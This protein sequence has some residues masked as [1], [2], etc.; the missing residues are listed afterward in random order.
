MNRYTII[1]LLSQPIFFFRGHEDLDFTVQ[2]LL[3]TVVN[4]VTQDELDRRDTHGDVDAA[5]VEVVWPSLMQEEDQPAAE[6]EVPL[7]ADIPLGPQ[8]EFG[9][10]PESEVEVL[11]ES[12]RQ[13]KPKV[14]PE[15]EEMEVEYDD[16][17]TANVE[18]I[19][20]ARAYARSRLYGTLRDRYH[21]VIPR[22]LLSI[23]HRQE[24]IAGF[25]VDLDQHVLRPGKTLIT[26]LLH[27]R[28][29]HHV[30]LVFRV[31]RNVDTMVD[32]LDAMA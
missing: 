10:D 18:P 5:N 16:T 14:Q 21:D 27:P 26:T 3:K 25:S 2:I 9:P 12:E 7:G 30:L 11:P 32:V 19:T 6:P 28:G 31:Q 22:V 1:E 20:D 15:E 29:D 13:L 17:W 4:S 24:N 8:V 23:N